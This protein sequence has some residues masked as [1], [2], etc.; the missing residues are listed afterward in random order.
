M[1]LSWW[2]DPQPAL[3]RSRFWNLVGSLV[4]SNKFVIIEYFKGP[5]LVV[6]LTLKTTIENT[7]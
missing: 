1:I 3:R 7:I 2:C 6:V 5:D 4:I